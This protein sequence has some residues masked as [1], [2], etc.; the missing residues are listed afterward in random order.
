MVANHTYGNKLKLG[1]IRIQGI[2]TQRCNARCFG[3]NQAIGYADKLFADMTLDQMKNA[4]DQLIEQNIHVTR[5]TF[6]GGEPV[7]HKDLQEMIYEVDRLPTLHNGNILTNGMKA[8]QKMRDRIKLPPKFR[9]KVNPLDDENDPYSGKNK[10]EVDNIKIR[11]KKQVH[12]PYW[13]SPADMGMEAKFEHCTVR[14]W[15]GIGLDSSGWQMCGK[16]AMF[17]ALFGINASIQEGDILEHVNKP[18]DDICKHCQYGLKTG[19]EK[20]RAAKLY[21]DGKIPEVSPTFEKVFSDFNEGKELV[22]LNE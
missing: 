2:I 11:G 15:C 17:G 16:A 4:V 22:Q 7:L 13:I 19:E 18:I 14:G 6:T 9:W 8:S 21:F 20:K 3:C 5:F 1:G 12:L 10:R